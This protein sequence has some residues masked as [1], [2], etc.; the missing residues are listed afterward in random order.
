MY[1]ILT[2]TSV[3]VLNPLLDKLLI[4]WLTLWWVEL[5]QRCI[6][7]L[8]GCYKHPWWRYIIYV[9]KAKFISPSALRTQIIIEVDVFWKMSWNT[10]FRVH[11]PPT[12]LFILTIVVLSHQF[13]YRV[14]QKKQFQFSKLAIIAGLSSVI[15]NVYKNKQWSKLSFIVKI[16]FKL[17]K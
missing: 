5:R 13:I 1:G 15:D 11:S 17:M 9:Q 4:I 10:K 3:K 12:L 6:N 14:Y 7:E 8:R 2:T 16:M